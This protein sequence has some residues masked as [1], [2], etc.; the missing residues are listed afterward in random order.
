MEQETKRYPVNALPIAHS[1]NKDAITEASLAV[2]YEVMDIAPADPV[3]GI[4][5]A[6]LMAANEAALAMYHLTRCDLRDH[7]D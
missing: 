5:V 7:I 6:Q 4:L 3:E 1:K 2:S